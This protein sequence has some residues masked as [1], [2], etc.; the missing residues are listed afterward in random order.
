MF[1]SPITIKFRI[2]PPSLKVNAFKR[3]KLVGKMNCV[4]FSDTK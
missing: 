4:I 2:S 1:N 3:N